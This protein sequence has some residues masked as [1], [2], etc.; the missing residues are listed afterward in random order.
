MRGA[1]ARAGIKRAED[2]QDPRASV[3]GAMRSK[4]DKSDKSDT[5]LKV[6]DGSSVKASSVA[7]DVDEVI[8][9]YNNTIFAR[10][11][12][13]NLF[14]NFTLFIVVANTC[15][16][17]VDVQWNHSSMRG[18][19]GML[20]LE[21]A[22][23][24]I[25]NSFC[26]YFTMEVLFRFLAYR[27]TCYCIKDK[28]Y[29]FD[30]LLWILMFVETW[31]LPL[32]A[33]IGNEGGHAGGLGGVSSLRILRL[34]RL[35]RMA[36][37][38]RYSPE[39][40]TL[41]KGMLNAVQAVG[42]ILLF[43]I[44]IIYV[45][46]IMFTNQL[47]EPGFVD[48]PDTPIPSAKHM[49]S[50]LGSSMMTLFTIGVLGDN[51]AQTYQALKVESLWYHWMFALFEM[52][53]GIT[54]LNMLIGVLCQVIDESSRE[55]EMNRQVNGLR[56]CLFAAFEEVDTSKDG[57]ICEE[58]W[59]QIKGSAKVRLALKELGVEDNQIDE[60]LEQM[61]ESLFGR[62]TEATNEDPDARQGL[63]FEEFV[64]KVVDLR[65]DTPASALDIEM[66]KATIANE[67]KALK[68]KLDGL[69][70]R[71]GRLFMARGTAACGAAPTAENPGTQG[72]LEAEPA[73]FEDGTNWLQEVPTELLLQEL[74]SRPMPAPTA[75]AA[76][77]ACP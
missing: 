33:I 74:K 10:I 5:T 39:L 32:I 19:N 59:A 41:V 24:I 16:M 73:N 69:E 71:L 18:D 1:A 45:F 29:V 77:A 53:T 46:G 27:R 12:G 23:M 20:P 75:V 55:E 76:S 48:P 68:R 61:Q 50:D 66:L 57:L 30:F 44:V 36:R 3:A 38:M 9:V 37:L 34:L 40:M 47:G 52:I 13:N 8:V 43:I 35:T 11:S 25:E 70:A 31:L 49:F 42:F 62:P 6:E 64:E 15:W 58:E 17:M 28:W 63:C 72:R 67:D 21:P 4:S 14:Q 65:W 2:G 26:A 7:E 60:R 51:L 22:S 54:L 56:A